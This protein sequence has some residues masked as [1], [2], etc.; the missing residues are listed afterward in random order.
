M[1]ISEKRYK[2]VIVKSHGLFL[3][4]GLYLHQIF[5]NKIYLKIKCKIITICFNNQ[6]MWMFIYCSDDD[7]HYLLVINT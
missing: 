4:S 1:K 5:R 7:V 6:S 3:F 2:I